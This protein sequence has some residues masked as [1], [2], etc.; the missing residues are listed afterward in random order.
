[1][2]TVRI[3]ELKARLRE[4]LR[5]VRKGRGRIASRFSSM[6]G[7]GDDRFDGRKT[8]RTKTASLSE[9]LTRASACAPTITNSTRWA[10]SNAQ[11]SLKSGARSNELSPQEFYGGETFPHRTGPPIGK[12]AVLA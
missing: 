9:T 2:G 8:G 4:H 10:R 11:N 7:N 5:A 12:R 3:T 1:M 6:T